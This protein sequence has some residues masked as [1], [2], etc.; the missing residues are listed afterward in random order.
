MPQ[1]T[2]YSR[3]GTM[4]RR[5]MLPLLF[6]GLGVACA[7]QRSQIAEEAAA[8]GC[9]LPVIVAFVTPPDQAMFVELAR[10]AGARLGAPASLT[11]NLYSLTLGADGA[12][13]ACLAAAERLR[14]D[15]R[16]RAVNVDE[17][18]AINAP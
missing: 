8:V 7:Q 16:V 12:D 13:D 3:V 6:G 9:T 14:N 2:A 15:P 10:A 1:R 17:R 11:A 18:R 5:A 4:L